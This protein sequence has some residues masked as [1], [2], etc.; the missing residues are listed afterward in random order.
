MK[1]E[2]KSDYQLLI[3][4]ES[5]IIFYNDE[6][7]ALPEESYQQL[8]SISPR[9]YEALSTGN[10]HVQYSVSSSAFF[11][12][13]SIALDHEYSIEYSQAFNILDLSLYFDVPKVTKVIETFLSDFP[14]IDKLIPL[15]QVISKYPNYSLYSKILSDILNNISNLLS[16]SQIQSLD[17]SQLDIILKECKHSNVDLD[18]YVLYH[19]L[20]KFLQIYGQNASSLF[21][22]LNFNLLSDSEFTSLITSDNLDPQPISLQ[23]ATTAI[24]FAKCQKN[25]FSSDHF[26]ESPNEE[27]QS[28]NSNPNSNIPQDKNIHNSHFSPSLESPKSQNTK[29]FVYSDEPFGGVLQ[30]LTSIAGGNVSDNGLCKIT[31]SGTKFGKPQYVAEYDNDDFWWGNNLPHQFLIFDFGERSIT[32]TQYSLRTWS[33]G[34]GGY[35]TANWLLEGSND[36]KLWIELDRKIN[37]NDLN[38]WYEQAIFRTYRQM[39]CRYLKIIQAGKNHHGDEYM[40]F[41]KIEFFGTLFEV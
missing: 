15:F 2:L 22:Y 35:H 40:V 8:K 34:A 7:I 29:E 27:F 1:F 26:N 6:Q 39:K 9:L 12:F 14:L 5:E 37:N 28:L 10:R 38:G 23:I 17:V 3:K 32:V 18:N 25:F 31:A 24:R 33:G 21:S 13:L 19:L 36:G 30:Y 41:T 11:C 4:M 20:L 16:N